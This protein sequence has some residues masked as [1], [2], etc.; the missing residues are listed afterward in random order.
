MQMVHI[1]RAINEMQATYK[2]L[3]GL[4]LATRIHTQTRRSHSLGSIVGYDSHMQCSANLIPVKKKNNFHI[5]YFPEGLQFRNKPFLHHQPPTTSSVCVRM[6]NGNTETINQ[7]R[8]QENKRPGA[9]A[10]T[11][12]VR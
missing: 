7:F 8:I 1:I 2:H 12:C 4:P 11:I 9:R 3:Y 5:I 10:R 6:L